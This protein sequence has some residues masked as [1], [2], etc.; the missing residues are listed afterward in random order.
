MAYD[1][2]FKQLNPMQRS[3]YRQLYKKSFY[4]FVKDF[5]QEADPSDFV[6][7]KVVQFFCEVAQYMTKPWIGYE[8]VHIDLPSPSDDLDIID[9]RGDKRNLCI[10]IPPRH[11]KSMIFSVL[12]PVWTWI[13]FPSKAAA[14]SHNSSLAGD[15]NKKRQTTIN[16]E[17]FKFFY[18]EIVLTENSAYKMKDNRAG[19][20]YS[21]AREAMTGFGCDILCLDDITNAEQARR[22]KTEMANAWS[23]FTNTMPSRI[24]DMSKS[25]ILNIQQR[26][27]INDITGHIL[28]DSKISSEYKFIII[29]AQFEKDTILVCP[30]TGTKFLFKKGEYLW[31]ER[32]GNYQSLRNQVGEVVWQTQYLQ[33]PV[34]SDMAIIKEEMINEID[35]PD[36]PT[37]DQADM[38][39]AS[40]DFP[41]KDKET[42]DYFGSVTAYKVKGIIYI[43][44][45]LEKRM[46]FVESLSYVS[47][48][49][50][51]YFGVVQIIEDKANGSPILQ[52]AGE[53]VAGLQAFQPGTA[54]KSQR[55]ESASL[56]MP[57]IR[58]V[59][60]QFDKKSKTY[61]LSENL[62]N[63]KN[64]LI[65]YPYVEHDDIVDAFS[66]LILFV[67]M[68]KRFAVY[69]RSFNAL[70][71]YQESAEVN[72]L[73]SN[74]FFN[75]EGD[76]WKVLDI[77]VKYG[78]VN[79]LYIKREIQFK[80][81][82]TE[83]IKKLKEFEPSKN[84]FIDC[85]T[86][87]SLYGVFQEHISIESYTPD[88]FEQSVSDLSLAFA[89][90]QILLE[91]Q[92]KLTK[93]DIEN[94][95]FDKSKDENIMKFKT[96]K[97]GFVACIRA[98][99]NFYGGLV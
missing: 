9:V 3:L 15:L 61:K 14:I 20:L 4:S 53:E 37:I 21:M 87:E 5:W 59:R 68:D 40:H 96:Q 11:S 77:A 95:K 25:V 75:K 35:A 81:D 38:V 58:F 36:A 90:R 7:G 89:N 2:S 56:Y 63:L 62:Q 85:S 74:V 29:P 28:S 93:A 12:F 33:H 88:D 99:M 13:N 23:F 42:S 91:E 45:C 82:I 44:D 64:R 10:N 8:E 83:G 34:A 60:T 66:M 65:C 97:D 94:F 17:R 92:C 26:L 30:I 46:A 70:N 79:F 71:T 84:V 50:D 51:V 72:K 16:S 47:R 19:E 52:Q 1:S 49:S 48:L 86:S 24:N 55:L 78:A 32:F 39:Y 67:F 18:P 98:A 43:M 6:N 57:N 54:S 41:V 73:Y 80:A 76:S 27:A 22:D 31:P 69:G